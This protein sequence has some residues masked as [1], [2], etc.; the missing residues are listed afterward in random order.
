MIL[1]RDQFAMNALVYGT[2]Y[3]IQPCDVCGTEGRIYRGLYADEYD[4][5]CPC[6]NGTGGEV[7]ETFPIEL[8][9][10]DALMAEKEAH[11]RAAI[12]AVEDG[13]DPLALVRMTGATYAKEPE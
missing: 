1:L 9:D 10:L 8:S 4:D 11:Y 7:I 12:T 2:S 5:E 6:C 3:T 13:S